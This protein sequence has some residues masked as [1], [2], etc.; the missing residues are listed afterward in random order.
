MEV[1]ALFREIAKR[2]DSVE[3]AGPE[4]WVK[5]NHTGGL[6]H[7]PIRYKMR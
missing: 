6:K 2:V 1:E 5:T 3:L 4:E 7:L